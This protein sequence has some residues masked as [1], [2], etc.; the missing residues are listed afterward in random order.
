VA[1]N[2]CSRERLV[3]R[4][5]AT[6]ADFLGERAER[7]AQWDAGGATPEETVVGMLTDPLTNV[8]DWS[9]SDV[10]NTNDGDKLVLQRTGQSG[11]SA[12]IRCP[13]P[14]VW[15]RRRVEATLQ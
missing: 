1:V 2:S 15:Y 10:C 14:L 11:L 7:R 5:G 13:A 4:I 3:G 9:P 12:A 8:M 6:W